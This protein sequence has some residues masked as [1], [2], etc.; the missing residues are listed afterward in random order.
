MRKKSII[1]A[2]SAAAL[3]VITGCSSS[4]DLKNNPVSSSFN[5]IFIDSPVNGI[6]AK[7]GS[8]TYTTGSNG[9]DGGFG[10]CPIG[11]PVY[12]SVGKVELGSV[13][14]MPNNIFTPEGLAAS[15]AAASNGTAEEIQTES[16]KIGAFLLSLDDDGDYNTAVNIVP[17]VVEALNAKITKSTKVTDVTTA[18]IDEVI[19]E[20]K[21]TVSSIGERVTEAEAESH[22]NETEEKIKDGTITKPTQPEDPTTLPVT[23][24]SIGGTSF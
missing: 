14:E 16:N 3:L 1:L 18:K 2:V 17:A 12:F 8:F 10:P 9:T 22:M 15:A 11:S 24:G 13:S 5:G 20:A 21:K 7:C 6:T 19:T 23:T 4:S